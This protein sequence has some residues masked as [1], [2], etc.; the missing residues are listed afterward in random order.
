[1]AQA[2]ATDGQGERHVEIRARGAGPLLEP[3]DSRSPPGGGRQILEG[4]A[5][6]VEV[7]AGHLVAVEDLG[8][9][10]HEPFGSAQRSADSVEAAPPKETTA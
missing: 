4:D 7:H 10:S 1:M 5:L 8:V 6:E 2:L 9:R 3:S